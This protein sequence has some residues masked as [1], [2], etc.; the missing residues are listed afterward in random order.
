MRL[1]RDNH[2]SDLSDGCIVTIGNFDSMHLGHQVLI[3]RCR[4]LAGTGLDSAVVTFEPLPAALFAPNNAPPRVVS[5][6]QK[7]ELLAK[8]GMDLVWMMRFNRALAGMSARSFVE[9][10]IVTGLRARQVVVGEDFQFG[11]SRSGNLEL[12]AD[13]GREFGFEVQAIPAVMDAGERVSSTRIRGL[14][15]GGKFGEVEK[16][17]GRPFTMQGRVLRGT[18]LGRKLGYPTANMR[19]A[20]FPSPLAGVFAVRARNL[21]GKGPWRDG[22]SSLGRRPVVGGKEFL[23]E[24][25]LFDFDGDLYGR[26]LEVRFVKKLRNE[27]KFENLDA[28]VAQMRR[29]E[30]E[31]REALRASP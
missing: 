2:R 13:L 21:T 15:A 6:R 28:L 23:V 29:D 17:L 30:Q 26:R 7:L 1:F 4:E 10:V 19:P 24:V 22:V 27:Q 25:H 20:A 9:R 14:L 12:L 3:D 31:A 18:Q 11:R 5:V 8:S 16:L